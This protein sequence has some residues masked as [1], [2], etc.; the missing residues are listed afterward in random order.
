MK[1]LRAELRSD[2][3]IKIGTRTGKGAIHKWRQLK[4]RDFGPPPPLVRIPSIEIT[5]PRPPFV[6]N[7]PTPPP[8]LLADVIC[9]CPQSGYGM[10]SS[11]HLYWRRK[12]YL[13]MVAWT[14]GGK[15]AFSSLLQA[16]QRNFFTSYSRNRREV[17]FPAPVYYHISSS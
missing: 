6:R 2:F 13:P 4:F 9:E 11:D 5:Q 10:I 1:T 3:G 16:E 14:W 17:I 15:I 7:R 8:P 12:Y